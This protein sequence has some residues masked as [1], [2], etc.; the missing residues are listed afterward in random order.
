VPRQFHALNYTLPQYVALFFNLERPYVKDQQLRLGLLLGTNKQDIVDSIGESLI[1]DTPLLQID[2]SDWR[3]QYDPR[4]AQGALFS[5]NWNLPEKVRLQRLLEM[6]E[7]NQIGPLHIAPIVLLDTGAALTVTGSIVETSTGVTLDGIPVERDRSSSG[8][9]IAVLPTVG[10]TGSLSL[11]QNLVKLLDEDE[12][13]IDSSYVWRT[14][15]T[16]DYK[17]AV[18]E[19]NILELFIASRDGSLPEEERIGY[20]DL[21]LEHGMLRRKL[22]TDP[23]EIRINDAGDK[24]SLVLL[25]SSNPQQY[26]QVAEMMRDQWERLGVHVG[27]VIP[28]TRQDFEERLLKRDYDV[29][30]FGQSLLDNLDSY[31]YWHSSGVQK[32]TGNRND[33]RLDAYN[34]SQFTSFEA[35]S[36]LEII[37]QTNDEK[38]RNQALEELRELLESHVPAIFLYSPLYTYAYRGDLHGVALGNFSLHSDRFLTLNRWFKKQ[39][40][41]FLSGRGWMSFPSWL[42]H[43]LL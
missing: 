10:S 29:L 9:W 25:T 17:R 22:S 23:Q 8:S 19:Q 32:I 30:L 20:E 28:E 4:A 15:K 5:S 38:E 40:R 18:E 34:L 26:R 3:Y 41:E 6:R 16:N 13:I 12:N 27:I 39:Q 42:I 2:V 14:D 11:G 24:L 33:L 31:P 35:D 36:L 21:F 43:D 7:A 1:V 37:R